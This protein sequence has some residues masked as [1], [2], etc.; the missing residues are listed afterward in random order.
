[1]RKVCDDEKWNIH[2]ESIEFSVLGDRTDRILQI[3]S[4]HLPH[5]TDYDRTQKAL[6]DR[7]CSFST[8]FCEF[9]DDFQDEFSIGT[10]FYD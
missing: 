9:V 6:L 5:H 7:K 1:M 4:F 2:N 10:H 8:I 3:G